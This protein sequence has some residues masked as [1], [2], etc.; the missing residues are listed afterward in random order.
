MR[1]PFNWRKKSSVVSTQ[2]RFN[3]EGREMAAGETPPRCLTEREM[4]PPLKTISRPMNGRFTFFDLPF[5]AI[6]IYGQ[7]RRDERFCSDT[8][9]R[10]TTGLPFGSPRLILRANP[11][12]GTALGRAL[13]HGHHG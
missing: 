1:L 4:P 8:D 11:L 13:D 3:G 9:L 7:N 5:M 2:G 6:I 10:H 12:Y